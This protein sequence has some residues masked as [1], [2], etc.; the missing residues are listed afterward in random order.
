[1]DRKALVPIFLIVFVDILALTIILPLL[2]FYAERYGASAFVVGILVSS[3]AFCQFLSGPI[4]GKLSDTWGRRPVLVLSQIGTFIGLLVLGYAN[5]LALVFVGRII[6]GLTAGN[7]TVAQAYMSDI[8]PPDKRLSAYALIGISFGLG[9]LLGPAISG[10]LVPYGISAPIFAAAGLSFISVLLSFFW[11]K[12]P[13]SRVL[14]TSK[15][16]LFLSREDLSRFLKHR[17]IGKILL[18]FFIF[19]FVFSWFT[20]S[21]ALFLERGFTWDGRPFAVREVSYVLAVLGLYGII[22]QGG[23]IGRMNKRWGELKLVYMGFVAYVVGFLLMGTLQGYTGLAISLLISSFGSGVL[24]PA[25]TSLLTQSADPN[26]QGF[27]L[28]VSQS[29]GS[30]AQITS[31]LVAAALIQTAHLHIW[32]LALSLISGL[33]FWPLLRIDPK[34]RS[35]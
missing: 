32:A 15:R 7:L 26:D 10:F 22:L 8:S 12:E 35:A 11:L 21:F 23:L 27:V 31:P 33:A 24:R 14:A 18:L 2:P 3:F 4:L 5:S 34:N 25:L 28:G 29:L 1:M 6:D 20:S 17:F 30:L 19:S 9:F 16:G 13:R